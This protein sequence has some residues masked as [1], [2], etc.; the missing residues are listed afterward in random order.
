MNDRLISIT[1][2]TNNKYISQNL[3][4]RDIDPVIDEAQEFD[5]KPVLGRELYQDFLNNLT[6]TKYQD[7]LN[8][9]EYTP[10]GYTSSVKFQGVKEVLKYYVYARMVVLDGAKNTPSGFV[11]KTLENS[12]RLSG[13]QRTQMIAQA[14][15]GAKAHEDEM[16]FFL[17]NFYPDYP[18]WQS[19]LRKNK[20]YGFRM[21]AV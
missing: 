21:R 12:E 19:T 20:G 18:L 2:F 6:D 13:T 7:L 9:K 14:R 17:N 10:T 5:L 1:D 8:G 15:S 11:Q 16:V 3:D 4:D